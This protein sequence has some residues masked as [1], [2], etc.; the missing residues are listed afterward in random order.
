[1][2]FAYIFSRFG[3]HRIKCISG[4]ALI[5]VFLCSAAPSIVLLRIRERI[6]GLGV[7]AHAGKFFYSGGED[8]VSHEA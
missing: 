4:V 8:Y 2:V 6:M 7:G 3:L 1:M 5:I